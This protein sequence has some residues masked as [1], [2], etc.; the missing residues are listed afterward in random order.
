VTSDGKS[1]SLAVKTRDAWLKLGLGNHKPQ[2]EIGYQRE[3]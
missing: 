2:F 3:F 1:A